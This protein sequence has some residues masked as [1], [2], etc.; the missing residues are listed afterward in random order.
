M[1][2]FERHS[3]VQWYELL[4]DRLLDCLRFIPPIEAGLAVPSPQLAGIILEASGLLDSVFR[5]ISPDPVTVG[6]K[7]KRAKALD[8]EDYEELY[9]VQFDLPNYRS[10]FLVSPPQ[11]RCPFG[12]WDQGGH[13]AWWA[14]Y[15]KIKHN[16]IENLRKATLNVA[17]DA[18]CA[19]HQ[20]LSRVPHFADAVL[21]RHWFK[22]NVGS[23]AQA[24]DMLRGDPR[25]ASVSFLV[26]T[27]VFLVARGREGGLPAK[28]E[29]FNLRAYHPDDS[30]QDFFASLAR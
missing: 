4:E 23:P 12:A 20:V 25:W 15:N 18:M 3:V 22:S 6:G 29:D 17:I 13:L 5:E 19:L 8:M 7:Q 27:K 21:R 16:R 30:V 10:Y 24:L 26:G 14:D 9:K 1:D 2:E 11:V 28:L